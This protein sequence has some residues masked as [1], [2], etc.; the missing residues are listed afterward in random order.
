MDVLVLLLT[1]NGLGLLRDHPALLPDFHSGLRNGATVIVL[2]KSRIDIDAVLF[3][4]SGGFTHRVEVSS[5]QSASHPGALC[6][7]NREL[8][9]AVTPDQHLLTERDM[10]AKVTKATLLHFLYFGDCVPEGPFAVPGDVWM[11]QDTI[12]VRDLHSWS[13]WTSKSG[14]THPYVTSRY[15]LGFNANRDV[16]GYVQ[17]VRFWRKSAGGASSY[18]SITETIMVK[19]TRARWVSAPC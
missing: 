6:G 2:L 15:F 16:L 14:F 9:L 19:R 3:T 17:N 8:T 13:R 5:T 11:T 7:V 4:V 10:R 18:D 12:Y 1:V